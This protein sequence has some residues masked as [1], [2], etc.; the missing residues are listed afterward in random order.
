[1]PPLALD[2]AEAELLAGTVIA[3]IDDVT[4]RVT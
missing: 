2:D 4:A 3:A 1:M